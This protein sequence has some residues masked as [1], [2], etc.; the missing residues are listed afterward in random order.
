[1]TTKLKNCPF[2]DRKPRFNEYKA[3]SLW[4]HNI[5]DW[6]SI[7]CNHCNFFLSDCENLEG[8]IE[9]WNTRY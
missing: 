1:M 4:N 5:V 6:A 3:E 2:C 7:G 8:L 9:L